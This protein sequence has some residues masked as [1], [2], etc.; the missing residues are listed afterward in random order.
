LIAFELSKN[1]N[2]DDNGKPEGIIKIKNPRN[3]QQVIRFKYS[4]EPQIDIILTNENQN[5]WATRAI[6]D[7][8]TT[9]TNAELTDFARRVKDRTF[10]VVNVH[11]PLFTSSSE[12]QQES[13]IRFYFMAIISEDSSSLNLINLNL[14]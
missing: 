9:L 10:A 4:M 5:H 11:I 14:F 2:S 12:E 7:G 3:R 13:I 1:T 6:K 8:R